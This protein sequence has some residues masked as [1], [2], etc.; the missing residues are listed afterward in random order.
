MITNRTRAAFA[1]YCV[2]GDLEQTS[3]EE[4]FLKLMS[5]TDFDVNMVFP[6]S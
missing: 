6:H 2:Y 4:Q 3:V 1:H 5:F